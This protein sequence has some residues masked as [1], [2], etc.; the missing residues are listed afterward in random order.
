[1]TGFEE[2]IEEQRVQLDEAAAAS[3]EITEHVHG[4][5]SMYDAVVEAE[6]QHR[7]DVPDDVLHPEQVPSADEIAAEVERFLRGRAE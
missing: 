5:E 4:L 6:R 2:A 1:V 7:F 3:E